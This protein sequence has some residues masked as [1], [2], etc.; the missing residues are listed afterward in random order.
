MCSCRLDPKRKPPNAITI[1]YRR[2]VRLLT[3]PFGLV[4][5]GVALGFIW[6]VLARLGHAWNF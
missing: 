2:T 6:L 3:S 4:L 1:R 5:S